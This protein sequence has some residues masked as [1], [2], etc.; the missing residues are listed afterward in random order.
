MARC[1]SF[2]C[3]KWALVHRLFRIH[4]H[5]TLLNWV[6]GSS[7]WQHTCSVFLHIVEVYFKSTYIVPGIGNDDPR[8]FLTNFQL[9]YIKRKGKDENSIFFCKNSIKGFGSMQLKCFNLHGKS[10]YDMLSLNIG[11][12]EMQFKKRGFTG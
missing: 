10:C 12:A 8:F 3:K 2:Y 6:S 9:S 4:L 7:S 1:A 11:K 5:Y